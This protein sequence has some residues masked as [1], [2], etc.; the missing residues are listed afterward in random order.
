MTSA[1]ERIIV[2]LSLMMTSHVVFCQNGFQKEYLV[3]SYEHYY[4]KSF[5]PIERNFWIVPYD[6]INRKDFVIYP[7]FLSGYYK[8]DMDNCCKGTAVDPDNSSATIDNNLDSTLEI[9]LVGLKKILFR[10]RRKIETISKIWSSGIKE[11]ITIYVTPV[12]G[13]FCISDLGPIGS[14]RSGYTGKIS[15]PKSGFKSYNEFWT[16]D[17]SKFV[18][19]QDYAERNFRY[20]LLYNTIFP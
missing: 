4:S 2:S 1:T 16:S 18:I 19:S 14:F 15:I 5:E 11:T 8:S 6:S 10:G 20:N 3:I 13:E 17:R 7:L 9:A 12:K